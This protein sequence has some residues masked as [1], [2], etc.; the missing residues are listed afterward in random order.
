MPAQ[1]KAASRVP[2][3]TQYLEQL[4]HDLYQVFDDLC[5]FSLFRVRGAGVTF[6][7]PT[8]KT[9]RRKII[10]KAYSTNPEDAVDMI[11]SLVLLDYLPTPTEFANKRDDIPNAHRKRLE[12][13]TAD[14]QLVTLASGHTLT[15]DKNFTRYRQDDPVA[16]YTLDGKGIMPS[17]EVAS[18]MKYA[19]TRTKHQ[20][21]AKKNTP[22][23]ELAEYIETLYNKRQFSGVYRGVMG[24]VY[25]CI[26]SNGNSSLAKIVYNSIC[27]S[28]RASFYNIVAPYSLERNY[29]ISTVLENSGICQLGKH[30]S[31][32]VRKALHSGNDKHDANLAAV[33]ELSGMNPES[34]AAQL[35]KRNKLRNKLFSMINNPIDAKTVVA[36]TY[37]SNVSGLY[38]DLL[39]MYCHICEGEEFGDRGAF[40]NFLFSIKNVFNH[41]N[42]FTKTSTETGFALTMYYN[43]LKSDA[44][45]YVPVL[46]KNELEK[47][48]SG[49]CIYSSLDYRLPSPNSVSLFTIQFNESTHTTTGGSSDTS[50]FGSMMT[51]MNAVKVSPKPVV[52]PQVQEPQ[53]A[54]QAEPQSAPQA[55]PQEQKLQ[56]QTQ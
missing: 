33:I 56:T 4:D 48:K 37:G 27:A 39:T 35:Q 16:V 44:F 21:S 12:V 51:S 40:N 34:R 15:V 52:Q 29:D 18:D 38:K 14:R 36:K 42:S 13:A 7:Y 55:E 6:L 46:A 22:E 53:S 9:Y 49:E 5:L 11:K 3:L 30:S 19:N 28:S 17:G 54:P 26:A 24:M 45:L 2:K 31:S 50:Y 8:D 10:N 23:K 32:V 25:G 20:S 1:T 43:L 47:N 41:K